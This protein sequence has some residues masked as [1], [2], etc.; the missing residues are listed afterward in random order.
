MVMPREIRR[1]E[2][3]WV[4]WNLGRGSEQVGKRPALIIQNDIG[5]KYS[6]TTIVAACSTARE[7]KYPFIVPVTRQESGL[8][9]DCSI[10]LSGI[11]TIDKS[12]LGD[13]GGE[14][15]KH[16]MVEADEAIK[17]SLGLD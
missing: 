16:K 6:P 1:G 3:Y 4:D 9:K 17:R 11:L 12:R 2:I 8:P 7:K 10:N 5:N 13:K 14:L 15:T